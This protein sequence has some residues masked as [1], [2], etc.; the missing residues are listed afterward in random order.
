MSPNMPISN[1]GV[2]YIAV[3]NPMAIYRPSQALK[4]KSNELVPHS[5][6]VR[7]HRNGPHLGGAAELAAVH[8]FEV[9]AH[10]LR[11]NLDDVLQA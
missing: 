9:P 4:M 3:I 2:F 7:D 8:R 1:I 10:R 11:D 6:D 5:D